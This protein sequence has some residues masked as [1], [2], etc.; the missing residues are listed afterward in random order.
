MSSKNSSEWV[1]PSA[2]SK[3]FFFFSKPNSSIEPS[4]G[5]NRTSTAGKPEAPAAGANL[6][7]VFEEKD[8]TLSSKFPEANEKSIQGRK[9]GDPAHPVEGPSLPGLQH[10]TISPPSLEQEEGEG[11]SSDADIPD[12]IARELLDA[13][14][15]KRRGNQLPATMVWLARVRPSRLQQCLTKRR[16]PAETPIQATLDLICLGQEPSGPTTLADRCPR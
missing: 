1:T 3:K 12:R 5:T 7:S 14:Q 11:T 4:L 13:L 9:S 2:V 6:C 10:V 15:E 8:S 16:E